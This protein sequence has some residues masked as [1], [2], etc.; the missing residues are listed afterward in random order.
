VGPSG[1]TLGG[2]AGPGRP[3][4]IIEL[5][6]FSP[7]TA[8]AY[9]E[10][11][12][13]WLG[14]TGRN[15]RVT[16]A[17]TLLA[18]A[19]VSLSAHAAAPSLVWTR[20]YNGAA[21]G[22]DNVY[23]AVLDPSGNFIVGGSTTVA[24][25][26]G[27]ML[28]QVLSPAG[29][30][31]RTIT[32]N[33]PAN[34][35]EAAFGVASDAAGDIIA[36]GWEI[37]SDL[38]QGENWLVRKY[39]SAG[40]LLWSRSLNGS[41][42]LDDQ[43]Q[44]VTADAAGNVYAA[45][46]L[47][48]GANNLQWLVAKYDTAGALVWS[49]T[50]RGPI[51]QAHTGSGVALDPAGNVIVIGSEVVDLS[52]QLRN[53]RIH[54][55]DSAGSLLWSRTAGSPASMS[56]D[57]PAS[58]ITD[59]SQNIYVGG[60]FDRSDLGQGLNWEL[61][62]YD[63]SGN[64]L[65]SRSYTSPGNAADAIRRIALTP[66]GQLVAVGDEIVSG[67]SGN[68]RIFAYSPADG[69]VLWSLT[70]N[71]A[72]NGEDQA[73]GVAG[74]PDGSLYV[75][76][77]QYVTGQNMNWLTWKLAYTLPAVSVVKQQDLMIPEPGN[78]VT[79][80]IIVTNTGATT[81]TSLT[82]V[83]T[84]VPPVC[85]IVTSQPAGFPAPLRYQ[86]TSGS[87]FVWSQSGL[88]LGCGKSFTFTITGL[89]GP[90]CMDMTPV[91][92]ALATASDGSLTATALSNPTSFSVAG[93]VLAFTAVKQQ[94]PA[95][96]GTGSPVTYRIIITNTGSATIGSVYIC[97]TISAV[98][99]G[100]AT[101]RPAFFPAPSIANTP[102]GTRY[103]WAGI[104]MWPIWPGTSYTFTVTGTV[105]TVPLTQT[106]SNTAWVGAASECL[107][108]RKFTNGVGFSLTGIPPTFGVMAVKTQTGGQGIGSPVV[109]NIVV[110][111]TGNITITGL[112]V[113]DTVSPLV[114][115]EVAVTPPGWSAPVLTSIATGTR[116]VWSS[117]GVS[118]ALGCSTTF[119]I[120]GNIG[121]V[122]T[123]Q[124]LSNT[125]FVIAT[126]PSDWASA[127]SNNV[128]SMIQPA[129]FGLSVVKTQVPAS[130]TT[131]M[132]VNYTIV[133]ANTG[134][135]TITSITVVDTVSKSVTGTIQTT[136]GG[137]NPLPVIQSPSGS[138]Y[139]W[140]NITGFPPGTSATFQLDGTLGMACIET[141]VSNTAYVTAATACTT[142]Q[143]I[144]NTTAFTI[145]APP[146]T[147]SA[148]K[149][150]T[151]G[152]AA[153]A[154]VRYEIAVT[155]TGVIMLDALT[156]VDTLSAV[157]QSVATTQP[158]F[159]APVVTSVTGSGTRYVWSGA[160]LSLMAGMTATISIDGIMGFVAAPTAVSNTA[161]V[162]ARDVVNCA[163]ING[164]TNVVGSVVTP[165]GAPAG[166]ELWAANPVPGTAGAGADVEYQLGFSNTGDDT[167]F[168][169]TVTTGAGSFS[170]R[171]K[172]PNY[173][174]FLWVGGGYDTVLPSWAT[175]L[176]GPWTTGDGTGS[177]E[178][179][180][181]RWV[182]GRVG[183]HQSG[184]LLYR[185]EVLPGVCQLLPAYASATLAGSVTV[186]TASA[187]GFQ[188]CDPPPEPNYLTAQGSRGRVD[189]SWQDWSQ[190]SNP[191]SHYEV[192]RSTCPDC[193]L[194]YLG[195]G[196]TPWY[197]LGQGQ[198]ADLAVTPETRY[199]YRVRAVDV[200]GIPGI[201][202][203]TVSADT[204]GPTPPILESRHTLSP[205]AG[206]C[207]TVITH[208]VRVT[209]PRHN[210]VLLV[211]GDDAPATGLEVS[212]SFSSWDE[213]VPGS[214]SLS[215]DDG[216]T[217]TPLTDANGDDD[218]FANSWNCVVYMTDMPEG[219]GDP[220]C[221]PG[222]ARLF[223]YQ[224]RFVQSAPDPLETTADVYYNSPG[225]WRNDHS[226]T[227]FAGTGCPSA[228]P[229]AP[230]VLVAAGTADGID[231]NWSPA[232][233]G[234][235]PI[236]RYVIERSTCPVCPFRWYAETYESVT[237]Y[238][239]T[240]IAP[241]RS[242]SYRVYATDTA[243]HS[244]DRSPVAT[245]ARWS[246]ANPAWSSRPAMPWGRWS[247]GAAV[248]AGRI[249]VVGGYTPWDGGLLEYTPATGAWIPKTPPAVQ[250]SRCAVGV[251]DGVIYAVGA[252][253]PF[254][255]LEAY[256][257]AVDG[258]TVKAPMPT[259]RT[260]IAGAVCDG[261]L[262]VLGGS[263]YSA[264][265][266]VEAY[267]PAT[268]AWTT[269]APMPTPR[270]D[271]AAATVN[272][273]IYAV[274][275]VDSSW[276]A[277][278][279]GTV[280]AYDPVTNSWTTKAPMPTP[281]HG[282][283]TVAVGGTLYAIGGD[284][285][286]YSKAGCPA[287]SPTVEA[288]DPA[289]DT[290]TPLCG[291]TTERAEVAAVAIGATLYAIGGWGSATA[292]EYL[293]TVE[294][295][296]LDYNAPVVV[297][298]TAPLTL[299]AAAGAGFVAL[300]WSPATP[301]TYPVSVY[302]IYRAS[303][304]ACGFAWVGTAGWWT[305][306]YT[307]TGV[308]GGNT[309]WY[310]VRARDTLGN[311][312]GF[313]PVA[314]ATLPAAVPP[315][316]PPALVATPGPSR[317]SLDWTPAPAGDHPVTAYEILRATCSAC[318]F[319]SIATV[320][321]WNSSWTDQGLPFDTS[322]WY[323]VRAIDTVGIIGDLSPVATATVP[324]CPGPA[325]SY[326]APMNTARFE[327][328]AAVLG[329]RIYVAGGYD[330]AWNE[331]SSVEVY[332]PALD[333]WTT[334][335][336]LPIVDSGLCM[337]AVGGTL[338]TLSG[339]YQ[340][341]FAYDPATGT[342]TTR[343]APNQTHWLGAAATV[344]GTLYAIGGWTAGGSYNGVEAYYPDQNVW[345]PV[346]SMPTGRRYFTA[347]VADGIIY[348]I[349][350][351]NISWDNVATVEA[352]DPA[353]GTWTTVTALPQTLNGLAAATLGT[354]VFALGGE[355]E[356]GSTV[357]GVFV[358]QPSSG[359][360][361]GGCPMQVPRQYLASVSLD[362]VI[363]A[364]GGVDYDSSD[365]WASVE[366][367][368]P[369]PAPPTPPA[370]PLTLT[371]LGGSG[372]VALNWSPAADGDYPVTA[373]QIFRQDCAKCGFTAVGTVGYWATEYTNTGLP[374]GT[375]FWYRVRAIDTAAIAGGFS[376]VA[377]AAT[378][379][380]PPPP[381]ACEPTLI[382]SR[383]YNCAPFNGMDEA[384]DVALDAS[385]AVIVAGF[386][387]DGA[388]TAGMI[389][390]YDAGG[391]LVWSVTF[392]SGIGGIAP[393][394]ASGVAVDASGGIY[395][396][397]IRWEGG[398][399]WLLR[400]YAPNGSF[401]W[402]RSG[403]DESSDAQGA[404]D[405]AV[406]AAGN[407][408]VVGTSTFSQAWLIQKYTPGGALSW[409][410]TYDTPMPGWFD[411]PR[412]VAL[413]A[414]GNAYVGGDMDTGYSGLRYPNWLVQKYSPGGALLWSRTFGQ[415]GWAELKDIAVDS[416]GNAIA[417]GTDVS[418]GTAVKYAPDGT[419]LWASR[420][421][422][423]MPG[424]GFKAVVAGPGN[425][426]LVGG[427]VTTGFMPPYYTWL[428]VRYGSTGALEWSTT[429]DGTESTA[430]ELFG[431]AAGAGNSFVAV[432][433]KPIQ[434]RDWMIRK[435]VDLC[436]PGGP[437]PPAAP[438]T[439]SALGTPGVIDLSWDV[440]APGT[441]P[442]T[443]Y[444]IFRAPC[445]TCAFA[446]LATVGCWATVYADAGLPLGASF[447]YRVRARDENLLPGSFS[448]VASATAG[449]LV[450]PSAPPTL[451][452]QGGPTIT[453]DWGAATAGSYP[454]AAYEIFRATCSGCPAAL[455][456]TVG[457]AVLQYTD[458]AVEPGLTYTYTVRAVDSVG[459]RGAFSPPA[460]ALASLP[461]P[462]PPLVTDACDSAVWH[463]TYNGP[464][465]SSDFGRAVA[466][467]PSGN[468]IV[469]GS[470]WDPAE[471]SNWAIRKYDPLGGFL[472]HVTYA[473]PG[474][475][476][477]E[478]SG[479]GTDSA[480][481]VIAVGNQTLRKYDANG[482]L[483]WST[484]CNSGW[485]NVPARLKVDAAGDIY[486]GSRQDV[487]KFAAGGA[488]LWSFTD[489]GF[490]RD[491]TVDANGNIFRVGRDTQW[492][493]WQVRKYDPNRVLLWTRLWPDP[494][495]LGDEARDAV[496]DAD[497]NLYVV[498]EECVPNLPAVGGRIRLSKYDASGSL[499]WTRSYGGGGS[500]WDNASSIAL[501]S[502]GRIAVA[503]THETLGDMLLVL[504]GP[505]GS[506]L[507]T[508]TYDS[509]V[510]GPDMADAVA[511]GP[512]GRVAIAGYDSQDISGMYVD[513]AV[514]VYDPEPGTPPTLTA[515]G[516]LGQ[517]ALNWSPAADGAYAVSAYQ[518]F[519]ATCGT[520]GFAPLASVIYWV[521]EYTDTGLP[522]G[523]T[524]WYEV[525]AVDGN[526]FTGGFS[527]IASATT[528]VVVFPPS[529]PLTLTALGGDG[530][531]ALEWSPATPGSN[532]LAV[533]DV[534][535]SSCA[536]C[537]GGFLNT[538]PA[539][540]TTC[541][542]TSG[543]SGE[544][545]WYRV[546]ARD[547]V[548]TTGPFGPE[549][550]ATVGGCTDPLW[551]D[552][553][554]L[555][556]RRHEHA[557]ATLD[558]KIWV[559]GGFNRSFVPVDRLDMY[560]PATNT[561]TTKAAMHVARGGL[562]LAVLGGSLYAVGG[563]D[564]AGTLEVYDPATDTWTLKAPAPSWHNAGMAAVVGGTLYAIGGE[565]VSGANNIVE[566][567]DPATDT[568]TTKTPMPTAR[569]YL[570]GGAVGGIIYAVGGRTP[571]WAGL[572]AVEAYDP[573]TDTWTT[574]ADMP[575]PR[576]ALGVAVTG[577]LL[578]ALA[579]GYPSESGT[580]EVYDP[581]ANAWTT[582]CPMQLARDGLA[583]AAVGGVLY[584][585]DGLGTGGEVEAAVV[586]ATP[587][588][589]SAPPTLVATSGPGKID[590][591][592]SAATAGDAPLGAYEVQRADCL[593]CAFAPAGAV[594]ATQLSYTDIYVYPGK[595]YYYR[596][597]ARDV[598]GLMGAP[599]PVATAVAGPV[600]PYAPF[601]IVAVGGA[602]HVTLN[603][604]VAWQGTNP[605]AG[606]EIFRAPMSAGTY[607][608][609]GTTS[610]ATEWVDLGL[611]AGQTWWY[612]VRAVDTVGT[613]G[614]FSRTVS[615]T[616]TAGLSL[617]VSKRMV[618][619]VPISEGPVTFVISAVNAGTV[620]VTDLLVVDTVSPLVTNVT[621]DTPAGIAGPFTSTTPAGT[622]YVWTGTGLALEPGVGLTFTITGTIAT[623]CASATLWNAAWVTAAAGAST[624]S[625]RAG[626][627]GAT[628]APE[629]FYVTASAS[630]LEG[631][632]ALPGNACGYRI[633]VT[634]T[635]TA[636]PVAVTIVD[637]VSPILTGVAT[638]QPAEFGAPVV[639]DVAGGGTRY[640][641]FAIVVP[642][643]DTTFTFTITGTVGALAG[644]TGVS[645]TAFVTASNA[646]V[647]AA[648]PT[649][650]VGH[651]VA[652]AYVPPGPPT[653]LT[654]LYVGGPDTFVVT[655]LPASPGT[656]PI[657]QYDYW[658]TSCTG[659]MST[660]A[661]AFGN[662]G[663]KTD[664]DPNATYTVGVRAWD[665]VG[666]GPSVTVTPV[667]PTC[668]T[669]TWVSRTPAPSI[670]A[671]AAGDAIG[672]I[673]Y[674]A[675]GYRTG[676]L[677][678]LEAYDTVAD[679]WSTKA[680][681][682][683]ARAWPVAEAIGGSLYVA[684]G[685]DLCN[686]YDRLEV[687][688]P[689]TDT[690]KTRAPMPGHLYGAVSA[691]AGDRLYVIGGAI[692]GGPTNLVWAY[693]PATNAWT[694]KAPMPAGGGYGAAGTVNGKIYV[695]GG[696][697]E[698]GV[699][700]LYI[701]DPVADSW[702]SGPPAPFRLGSMA[703]ATI[704]G[705]LYVTGGGLEG[706]GNV[707]VNAVM[708]FDTGTG[709]WTTLC[710][711]ITRRQGHVG[712]AIDG[713]LYAV[714]GWSWSGA[715]TAVEAT[716]PAGPPP[717]PPS[718]PLTLT[719]SGGTGQ[720]ALNWSPAADGT[721]PVTAYE[722]F[723][724]TCGTCGF[725]L[726][727]TVGFWTT[728]YADTGLPA[729][730]TF[731]Y[732]VRARDTVGTTGAF[733][734]IAVATTTAA[735][736]A[737]TP[738]VVAACPPMLLWSRTFAVP[739]S[740]GRIIPAPDAGGNWTVSAGHD[741][742]GS[743]IWRV[744][745]YD[746]AG[747]EL[748]THDGQGVGLMSS[749]G[750][751]AVDGWGESVAAGMI[752][753]GFPLPMSA[754]AVTKYDPA[755]NLLWSRTNDGGGY[756][757]VTTDTAGNLVL[758]TS[759][760]GPFHASGAVE[761]LNAAGDQVWLRGTGG[762][763][764]LESGN[765][766]DV[767]TDAAG[768]VYA[769]GRYQESTFY[770]NG[771][772][773]VRKFDAGGNVLWSR[774]WDGPAVLG[775]SGKGIAVDAGGNVVVVGSVSGGPGVVLRYD[776]SGALLWSRTQSD[777]ATDI[778]VDGSGRAVTIGES[779]GLQYRL[780]SYATDGALE[781]TM[782]VP[783]GSGVA[784]DPAGRIGVGGWSFGSARDQLAVYDTS[785]AVPPS[786]PPGIMTS[787]CSGEI[788]VWW[789]AATAGTYPLSA[790]EIF[791]ATCGTC[792]FVSV[793]ET[794]PTETLWVDAGAPWGVTCSYQIRARDTAGI[795]G[796]FGPIGSRMIPLP[797]SAPATLVAT[798]GS[799][800]VSLN[801]SPAVAGTELVTAYRVFRGTC[802]TCD[803]QLLD[804][805]HES[806]TVYTDL[807]TAPGKPYWYAVR[808]FDTQWREGPPS[809][810]ATAAAFPCGD[811]AWHGLAPL[812][813]PRAWFGAVVINGRIV[814]FGG[815]ADWPTVPSSVG[816]YDPATDA[817]TPKSPLSA[818]WSEFAA[819][820]IGGVIYAAGG[821]GYGLPWGT[822]AAY[823]PGTG[824]WSSIAPLPTGREF[825]VGAVANGKLY[826]VGGE[827]YWAGRTIYPNVD[828]Y[829]PATDTWMSRAPIPT[830]R[831][832]AAAT[833]INGKIYVVGG[834]TDYPEFGGTPQVTGSLE[835]YDPGTDTWTT[836][837]P[838]PTARMHLAAAVVG[839]TLYAVGGLSGT[840]FGFVGLPTVE[841]YDPATN[842][843]TSL[844]GMS[845]G[846][847]G[848][849]LAAIGGTLY[850]IGGGEGSSWGTGFLDS[851][852]AVAL[853]SAS[854]APAPYYRIVAPPV[855]TS[856]VPFWITVVVV[857]DLDGNTR[858][859]YCG[860]S[861]FTSTDP[862]AVID[863]TPMDAF[864]FAWS[865]STACSAPPDEDGV[866]GFSVILTGTG[867]RVIALS[868]TV[869]GD[870]A[871]VAIVTVTAP[872]GLTALLVQTP[873]SPGNLQ[874]VTY[875][876]VVTN[877]GTSTISALEVVDTV[878][879]GI[880]YYSVA[881]EQTAPFTPP[882]IAL[883]PSEETY[884]RW[885]RTGLTF[886]PGTSF[887]FTVTG[888]VGCATVTADS[889]AV[890]TADT[891]AGTISVITNTVSFT[892]SLGNLLLTAS[893][894]VTPAAPVAGGPFE[895]TI[896]VANTGT[897][898]VT[899][900]RLADTL[901]PILTVLAAGQPAV[902]GAPL[903]ESIAS[904]THYLWSASG[905]A[906]APGTSYTF[907]ITGT[908]GQTPLATT[909]TNTGLVTA[910]VQGCLH[911][912][913]PTNT[914]AFS[915]SGGG[916]AIPPSAPVLQTIFAQTDPTG[917]SARV[918]IVWA[919]AVPGTWPVTS[920]EVWRATVAGGATVFI[921]T[922]YER[923]YT[924]SQ[925]TI[926]DTSVLP[927]WTY[928]YLIRAIDTMGQAGPFL[929]ASI[930]VLPVVNLTK[931]VAPASPVPGGPV[932]YRIV[933]ENTG[934]SPIPT[935]QIWDTP[936]V[937]V[938]NLATVQP[939]IFSDLLAVDTGTTTSYRW[940]AVGPIP[941]HAVYTLT[942]T[943]TVD[944]G[945]TGV[946][947]NY[948]YFNIN[949]WSL[950][951]A[952][953][954]MGYSNSVC[955]TASGAGTVAVTAVKTMILTATVTG[956]VAGT[957]ATFQIV[958]TNTGTATI[959]N[960]VV[961]DTVS[962][963]LVNKVAGT[964]AGWAA[965]VVTYLAGSGTRF[966]WSGNG[967]VFAPGTSTTFTISGNIGV[968]CVPAS[969]SNTAFVI[970][971]D[972]VSQVEVF[973][974]V[975]GCKVQPATANLSVRKIQVPPAGST[976]PTGS[977]VTYA[978][979]IA[980]TGSATIQN[981]VV[982]DTVSP[983]VTAVTTAQPAAFAAPTVT[984][985]GTG[986]RYIW[987]AGAPLS[988][989]ACFTFTITGTVGLVGV[990]TSAGNTAFVVGSTPCTTTVLC[991]PGVGFLVPAYTPPV[992]AISA[993]KKLVPANPTIGG[994]ATWQIV[995][996]NT[997]SDTVTAL[998]V[999]DTVSPLLV[1000]VTTSQPAAM[1001][1002]PTLA[1003]VPGG[1004]R[1005]EWSQTGLS[1006]SP[1007]KSLTFT[1008]TGN[1009]APVCAPTVLSNTAFVVAAGCC[1010]TAEVLSNAAGALI[1011]PALFS[1012]TVLKAQTG[1013]T[1014]AGPIQY[1015]IVVTN[1016]GAAVIDSLVIVDT[1017]SPAVQA[1018]TTYQPGLFAAPVVTQ[1019]ASGTRYI[1020]SGTGLALGP[1021]MT[1022]TFTV[1023]GT[1024][1025]AACAPVA[1026]SNTAFVIAQT[1027]CE[1028]LIAFSNGVGSVVQPPVLSVTTA[1029]T[1030][1031][1032][1033]AP[1034][1035]GVPVTFR[1036]VVTNTGTGPITTL[1037]VVDT[1038][1039]SLIGGPF[1040]TGQPVGFL[1041]TGPLSVPSGTLFAWEAAT[1042]SLAPGTSFTFTITGTAGTVAVS[1043]G[1044]GNTA[1045]IGAAGGC[1046]APAEVTAPAGFVVNN[1047]A[1048]A[1049]LTA[1050]TT[1051][1052]VTVQAGRSYV[1053]TVTVVNTG[1054]GPATVNPSIWVTTGAPLTS[1055]QWGPSPAGPCTLAAGAN[1056]TFSWTYLAVA[1057]GT[1058]DFAGSA[1059]GTD[1060]VTGMAI[1061][1062]ASSTASIQITPLPGPPCCV[1063]G[1064]TGGCINPGAGQIATFWFRSPRSGRCT[1065][1066]VY[1067]LNG[1068]QVWSGGGYCQANS[1069]T[1070]IRWNCKSRGGSYVA[1071]GSY[1072]ALCGNP[1073][1074]R[1075]YV[1076]RFNIGRR[1077]R[1078]R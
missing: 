542:D 111:N 168:A 385:G 309:Y 588:P 603:W 265:A 954:E 517:I 587:E 455:L 869:S 614:G 297:P 53:W 157:V 189:L 708:A 482:T 290:W 138:V 636:A 946:L 268:D 267:N 61:R 158:G 647:A 71:G 1055:L 86:T 275:G 140:T 78:D 923:V 710:W 967:L 541:T 172:Q 145:A 651:M 624:T 353:A 723:R 712:A 317:I 226:T 31:V 335:A 11:G 223:R 511:G 745:R 736:P 115:N 948:A 492:G 896:V 9:M 851:M 286:L 863:G 667:H 594:S 593:G 13:S 460:S 321:W 1001:G 887:T 879:A 236:T 389:R 40:A 816:E 978:I 551:V 836:K 574:K 654:A 1027:W 154:P 878:S 691:V 866:S 702:T 173:A 782:S 940:S 682:P 436:T 404:T 1046:G 566:A 629:I 835:V 166:L 807:A 644:L 282:L 452:A 254:D 4:R 82:V 360:W 88:G 377:S 196:V 1051:A 662:V 618:P 1069:P 316:Q 299:T 771:V 457:G 170:N 721:F 659:C 393:A 398:T 694:T 383:T 324:P 292:S 895:Y 1019:V 1070:A 256:D 1007:G 363:Y 1071:P 266:V 784:V 461:P 535:R 194:T 424:R 913:F 717:T 484:T 906:M 1031:T 7:G 85:C 986:T 395:V 738:G 15:E 480:G 52:S 685:S 390:K 791:R 766:S 773:T 432:G 43:A 997:G 846:R 558:G 272:G 539:T 485:S 921:G 718:A 531:V 752:S 365:V 472:W 139:G 499:L 318:P 873:D 302:Q 518:I 933:V 971:M 117:S 701:Y 732:K 431:I 622:L 278:I 932:I 996:T 435:Y 999:V 181:L 146:M 979:V 555:D 605:V 625:F 646:C 720:I 132:P 776:S 240:G 38:G 881:G 992:V 479:I 818:R 1074:G 612:E 48:L 532:P 87:M 244:S 711:M 1020:W 180:Y 66:A 312:G 941:P 257:P 767:A 575:T 401:L 729:G 102:S 584:A 601:W 337:A 827:T 719:A 1021:S 834:A 162:T 611:P 411:V 634:L 98:I 242:Y 1015:R 1016:T 856:G 803:M 936:P 273:I 547:G 126:G 119:S 122:C 698:G 33:S 298:P 1008:I 409:Q 545:Y 5:G 828:E 839:G 104:G 919:N 987:S 970:A 855:V 136:P 21:N 689:A 533:Y 552:R 1037:S 744:R 809:P 568:W 746:P 759:V 105:G 935:M 386:R 917:P 800:Q 387:Q 445:E 867:T 733:S 100:Q 756:G 331:L 113:V 676:F 217:W 347:A 313:S 72:A 197:W 151:G 1078:G 24:G 877:T 70:W 260:G 494:Y 1040:T 1012:F 352:F 826:V 410:A 648:L 1017:V 406:D 127:F 227:T 471:S 1009:V 510:G 543:I 83:D 1073:N 985:L 463:R 822:A 199:W 627:V 502:F 289:T 486:V 952:W 670:R 195:T 251:I 649:N 516:G 990:A 692:Y 769:T 690:W 203:A 440:A 263:Y 570:D 725:S 750:A 908:V 897:A 202:S 576:G 376:P 779:P 29:V 59:D 901:P 90:V 591:A 144:S 77:W 1063:T 805:V 261:L 616:T 645:N 1003:A 93:P 1058:V 373:Y 995:V 503:G 320:G 868:D 731:W 384:H 225:W 380:P 495:G 443:S 530:T 91:N 924:M 220:A 355:D 757:A 487:E 650:C 980:N 793:H 429:P 749:L 193:T 423:G 957:P 728:E 994:P 1039:P 557:A 580:V 579:G 366:A 1026:V 446:P 841:A 1062:S 1052:P 358:R 381:P 838:M 604:W 973:S 288:Y 116:F 642:G 501:D 326:R 678:T 1028:Q 284:V 178:P 1035:T 241:G 743:P 327:H 613:R 747:S 862:A 16:A 962:P 914:V 713:V 937:G 464:G 152:D 191:L 319:T 238:S 1023:S 277:Q 500:S 981:L 54:K 184:Y 131:G 349:G 904:G 537:T 819:G 120:S 291:M 258:W 974:N 416:A 449:T 137:F 121:F 148:V 976:I 811:P 339:W 476:V 916:A 276:P 592:W 525:R 474:A 283:A 802:A 844:C 1011:Q 447:W 1005:Y 450:P 338:Y 849:S 632:G 230:A 147:F 943:G 25:Q 892:A 32:Y 1067:N 928:I 20:T 778:A 439:L 1000:N 250:K 394:Q 628:L 1056:R 95:N 50:Y 1049:Q 304:P 46:Y 281:R 413:D 963:L 334:A 762:S 233:A 509:P 1044:A 107:I 156:I 815:D 414:S 953:W 716:A 687:Y 219:T 187:T 488:L 693:D 637:T 832:A 573:A 426:I 205:T 993:V 801:W 271:F 845:T 780:R 891:G 885:A 620:T 920:Y 739:A 456:K 264:T 56:D 369:A 448:P 1032:P 754:R 19:A 391:N 1029:Q 216:A 842:S 669:P 959:T 245:A 790:Y 348:A 141:T 253:W 586:G 356:A 399:Q 362:G 344:G 1075:R 905:L 329:N 340:E 860:T 10:D 524:F 761:K 470:E 926:T 1054:T 546:R 969:I 67:Q 469:G 777:Y 97:D 489:A 677:D 1064:G 333:T 201:M 666:F 812:S 109:F 951:A 775:A 249:Y 305:T 367:T 1053:V 128:W 770:P 350:G 519:R 820:T 55:Y 583:A 847:M 473:R 810:V 135:A 700:D 80:R 755:G 182:L 228:E 760:P 392:G 621:T 942:I 34:N 274:G 213:Y 171:V 37:R 1022:F 758:A 674:V 1013:G 1010:A 697:N 598:N 684:G 345:A 640:T 1066:V 311:T 1041:A 94:F 294:A 734:P 785:C 726:L 639:A 858:T 554:P 1018:V 595:P 893:K 569:D 699:D 343:A 544:T 512:G 222:T 737:W 359:T 506:Y 706:Y 514:R 581:V 444:E 681:M 1:P 768:N 607:A 982:V 679:T 368:A 789:G 1059:S 825:P 255:P 57:R 92:R 451:A 459:T 76:G 27:N 17:A 214:M 1042:A 608:L 944:P 247:H 123:P 490:A 596:I 207:G 134:S 96:P 300:N 556:D 630:L 753:T 62:K 231:L 848:L 262:Y 527:P 419:L 961:V 295:A 296:V 248:A 886:L 748:W 36:A 190:G 1077:G 763:G 388:G 110:T 176:G 918:D 14:G 1024:V 1045:F 314:S 354:T 163:E 3:F 683:T 661:G 931:S 528:D 1036:I 565:D 2:L 301:G 853:L 852:E 407:A 89:I 346:A 421:A 597:I 428:L 695:V 169:V 523:T 796:A 28:V 165:A 619:G 1061:S 958:V 379:A 468:V 968:T 824:T 947:C 696:Y 884:V 741:Q 939:P 303:C 864:D 890:V 983:V 871:G 688:D 458:L 462:P 332:D 563:D 548:G 945:A 42:N 536:G 956:A 491:V 167:A 792:A 465:N 854:A 330:S 403:P 949:A 351:Y 243:W 872:S 513:L 325:W 526:G 188:A 198:L 804:Q 323:E 430:E 975:A 638:S 1030:V 415:A 209:Y 882:T 876:L 160:G 998:T 1006:V 774:T 129:V 215:T 370:A 204:T 641:W 155:N 823:D 69:S 279:Y 672:T 522:A 1014:A 418:D 239:D 504:F 668:T 680:P 840:P 1047:A 438:A 589:P 434:D 902:F 159:G 224:T 374:D 727:A 208:T 177:G 211:C 237:T 402:E 58:V 922:A 520:C 64:L 889:R 664:C 930:P 372:Q 1034:G 927:D 234:T 507:C 41:G 965:P 210:D 212:S 704:G 441:S 880:D 232:T 911:T 929:S 571:S 306:E 44:A 45:G 498:G 631:S 714:G 425:G 133:V 221:S 505:D 412:G 246:C 966:V 899:D 161:Y 865:S 99:T 610:G 623:V 786:A 293:E 23:A 874:S 49:R 408:V 988:P 715:T 18:L 663:W 1050:T 578:Y 977:P 652:P 658:T 781:W 103:I 1043:T 118:L 153:G 84:V 617:V 12:M 938:V 382:W 964:P 870:I 562:A 259:M 8:N 30:V 1025:G 797:P 252:Y 364:I 175:S 124:A 453:L 342:W 742:G 143:M 397:G 150:Q 559:A 1004:T 909:V 149:T 108:D 60:W 643:P 206:P 218:G 850:A 549:A 675:G 1060:T 400:K 857:S 751:T 235:N 496:A 538:V 829:N 561:W 68:W 515:L 814:A 125:A 833:T 673:V 308:I 112:T 707:P 798:D 843:W 497:G 808:A 481:N 287:S 740:G 396:A 1076:V 405:V 483:V 765:T 606:Y 585:I 307:D 540:A 475:Q 270:T 477:D 915:V 315:G 280:E 898:T 660:V 609:A 51:A 521:T 269:K 907:T 821:M 1002:L 910:W 903:V 114:V 883:L 671:D 142:T 106:I 6:P 371:A 861:L 442:V 466:F 1065:V 989:G 454:L 508:R 285:G 183:P 35:N 787:A 310:K 794:G 185:A 633:T 582:K 806:V 341:L 665:G 47:A 375:T 164:F 81:L 553:A 437:T 600:P 101:D 417:V 572:D 433:E 859:D 831:W 420:Y 912:E 875:R 686:N 635:G 75:S 422:T 79:Y 467:D 653:G 830:P 322:F 534:F 730:T 626:P 960:L 564:I 174:G 1057:D 783:A 656:N 74:A 972:A 950:P 655:W 813:E 722:V 192:F 1068:W 955:F 130:P 560:D 427:S 1048:L 65:W 336:P 179:L 799:G 703:A 795:T 493:T 894:Y 991:T 788:T 22:N 361:I 657:E 478:V 567:Y 590:L 602:G 888:T 186:A 724:A 357:S 328:A 615:G 73:H 229:G 984:S 817:W 837:V 63:G 709:T 925:C 934:S 735:P 39:D 705:T 550:G 26:G 1038:L 764:D 599:G 529:A 577:G 1072:A 1033:A 772:L 200:A 378:D 900:V